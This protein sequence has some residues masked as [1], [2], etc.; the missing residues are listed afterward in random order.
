M[1]ISPKVNIC[2][3]NMS[4]GKN[5]NSPAK[6]VR[7]GHNDSASLIL[8]FSVA[9]NSSVEGTSTNVITFANSKVKNNGR[10]SLA[11]KLI[12][13]AIAGEAQARISPSA[14]TSSISFF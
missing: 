6:Y 14:M 12:N 11:E 13:V 5:K 9:V 4:F 2:S 8:K 3:P 7:R 1:P 10:N